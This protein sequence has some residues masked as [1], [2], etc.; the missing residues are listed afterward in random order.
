MRTAPKVMQKSY[1]ATMCN[2]NDLPVHRQK[3]VSCCFPPLVKPWCILFKVTQVT[4]KHFNL[5]G[6]TRPLMYFQFPW[7][8]NPGTAFAVYE[9]MVPTDLWTVRLIKI[10]E[11]I[12]MNYPNLG[13]EGSKN[14]EGWHGGNGDSVLLWS[15]FC[16][17]DFFIWSPSANDGMLQSRITIHRARVLTD[18]FN[19]DENDVDRVRW[20]SQLPEQ[21]S[22]TPMVDFVIF[23]IL[24]TFIIKIQ[25]LLLERMVSISPVK[26]ES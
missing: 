9:F 7:W 21:H 6:S 8:K 15:V 24:Y 2:L 18:W 4:D 22:W 12:I 26:F 16:R 25:F 11:N 20:P 10:V 17:H 1:S 13:L 14:T 5:N 23:S 3:V 19:E